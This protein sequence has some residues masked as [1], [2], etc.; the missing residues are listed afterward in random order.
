MKFQDGTPFNA[1]AVKYNVERIL[2]PATASKQLASELGPV[3][4]ETPDESTVR[5]VYQQPG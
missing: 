4:I 5:F 1:A 2:A 3:K